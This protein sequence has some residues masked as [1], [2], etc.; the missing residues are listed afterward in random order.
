E[1]SPRKLGINRSCTRLY[2]TPTRK[3]SM[4]DKI[5]WLT[6]CNRDPEVP[7]VVKDANPRSTNPICETEEYAIS[8]FRYFM[9]SAFKDPYRME[10]TPTIPLNQPKYSAE[11]GNIPKQIRRIP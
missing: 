7:S 4:V 11:S 10:I 9:D 8:F 3:K 5:P 2:N 6:I 1:A